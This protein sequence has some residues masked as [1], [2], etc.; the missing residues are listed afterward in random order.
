MLVMLL[1][2][3]NSHVCETDPWPWGGEAIFRNGILVGRVTT[4]SFGFTLGQHVLLGFVHNPTP[5][6]DYVVPTL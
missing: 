4:T 3:N 6:E 2:D 5:E 1:L